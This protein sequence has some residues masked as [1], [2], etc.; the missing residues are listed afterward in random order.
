MGC[1]NTEKRYEL[2][3][4]LIVQLAFMRINIYELNLE[5]DDF[6]LGNHKE[7][8]KTIKNFESNGIKWDYVLLYTKLSKDSA[9]YLNGIEAKY[10]NRIISSTSEYSNQ[11]KILR[12]EEFVSKTIAKDGL[13]NPQELVSEIIKR[14]SGISSDHDPLPLKAFYRETFSA[15]ETASANPETITGVTS[16]IK[17]LD[18]F[19]WGFQPSKVYIIAGR[20]SMGKSA[21]ATNI[22]YNA[23]KA[24]KK[25]LLF[26]LEE[27]CLS[28]IKR[29]LARALDF[30]NEDL[31]KGKIDGEVWSRIPSELDL[32]TNLPIHITEKTGLSSANICSSAR[33][34]AM[35]GECDL[36]II[37][38]IQEIREKEHTRHLEI[39]LAASNLR[40]LCKELKIPIII[41]SQLSRS[42]ESSE[43]KKPEM[44]HLKESGDLE[45]IAD[46]IM[47]LYR[48]RYYS[49]QP[50]DKEIMDICFAKNRNGRT[51][52]IEIG[53]IS[54]RLTC[55]DI[56]I[57]FE[58]LPKEGINES[59]NNNEP[60]RKTSF[61]TGYKYNPSGN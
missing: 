8:F 57:S 55:C 26:S 59:E 51:G 35:R 20:P 28:I 11:I 6:L 9:L 44:R 42:V 16:G 13:A 3:R 38:H 15:L 30:N 47:L 46:T 58:R 18:N 45:Q 40:A 56:D 27:D 60:R 19:T 31:N 17:D 21:L 48:E 53:F 49:K 1:Q 34:H 25:V 37:D 50:A 23:A 12:A 14:T 39:S 29:M 43:N 7:I 2:E 5:E 10:E 32:I 54:S 41:L 36:I 4:N 61:K 33:R 24:G 22:T 52:S